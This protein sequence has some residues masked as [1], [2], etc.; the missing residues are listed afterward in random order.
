MSLVVASLSDQADNPER[1]EEWVQA[2]GMAGLAGSPKYIQVSSPLQETEEGRIGQALHEAAQ[3]GAHLLVAYFDRKDQP[4]PW[5]GT[6]MFVVETIEKAHYD[7]VAQLYEV[8]SGRKVSTE[9]LKCPT[10]KSNDPRTQGIDPEV[11]AM[12][13]LREGIRSRLIDYLG[14][15]Q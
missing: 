7:W 4:K 9:V 13:G 5:M 2:L 11:L 1:C 6:T 8:S 10:L 14:R 3:A 12:R 15:R